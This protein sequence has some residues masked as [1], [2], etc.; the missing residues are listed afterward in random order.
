MGKVNSLNYIETEI[1][2]VKTRADYIVIDNYV[3]CS[4][5]NIF[6]TGGNLQ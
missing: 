5:Y 4:T 2:N 6:Y 3:T 1:I